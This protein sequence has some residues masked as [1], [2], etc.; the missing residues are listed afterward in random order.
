MRT[1]PTWWKQPS[2]L[3]FKRL[4]ALNQDRALFFLG[5]GISI[6]AGLPNWPD[7][8]RRLIEYLQA[9]GETV[10][11]DQL[12]RLAR[13]I[14]T[15]DKK[16]FPKVG[17]QLRNLFRPNTLW[18]TALN[19]IIDNPIGTNEPGITD[20]IVSLN[21]HCL[22]TTNYDALLEDAFQRRY[23]RDLIVSRPEKENERSL[24]H[25]RGQFIYKIHGDIRDEGSPIVLSDDDYER[26]YKS[27][28][29]QTQAALRGVLRTAKPILFAGYSHDDPY[30]QRFYQ[31]AMRYSAGDCAFA[32]VPIEGEIERFWKKL[33]HLTEELGITFIGYSPEEN[34]REILEFFQYLSDPDSFDAQYNRLIH[35]K[36]PTIV[37]LYCGGTIG[38]SESEVDADLNNLK[39]PLSV[40]KIPTRFDPRLGRLSER[41]SDWYQESYNLGSG[42]E[43]DL[44]WEV[45]PEETQCFSENA[46]PELW[47]VVLK[48]LE[49][50]VFKYF[51][52]PRIL[53]DVTHLEFD[54]D[55]QALP[56]YQRLLNLYDE[57]REQY[58]RAFDGAELT[59][60]QFIADFQSRYVLGIILLF[61]TD[62]MGYMVSA[63]SFGLQHM[64]C[65]IVVTGSNQPPDQSHFGTM[66]WFNKSD[67]WKNILTAVY[68]LQTF[69]HTLTD[70]FICFG[71]TIH[72]GVNVRK[73][74]SEMGPLAANPSLDPIS[75][76][77][78]GDPEPFVFRNLHIHGQYM[79]RLIDGIFCNNYYS[80]ER[81][82]YS[83][84]V[85]LQGE[86]VL[87]LRH[88]RRDPLERR[89]P[90]PRVIRSDFCDS[91]AILLIV[92]SPS[93]PLIDVET[94]CAPE[95][96][97]PL[98]VAL[99]E[100]YASGT[101]PT[102]RASNFSKLLSDLYK[103][104]IPIF[105]VSQY[106]ISES[107]QQYEVIALEGGL[108][109][110]V[111]VHRGLTIESA[112]PMFSLVLNGISD[113]E[114]GKIQ[115]EDKNTN[116]SAGSCQTLLAA[117]TRLIQHRLNAFLSERPNI[118][119]LEIEPTNIKKQHKSAQLGKVKYNLMRS[120]ENRQNKILSREPLS[121]EKFDSLTRPFGSK[122]V[123]L[124][125]EDFSV[126]VNE[127]VRRDER[128]GAG[129]DGFAALSDLGFDYGLSIVKGISK[130]L[131]EKSGHGWDKRLFERNDTEQYDLLGSAQI[132]MKE[133]TR[134]LRSANIA[135]VSV[136]EISFPK[137]SQSLPFEESTKP[138]FSFRITSTRLEE[139][140]YTD[141]KFTAVSF[142]GD[143]ADF[144]KGLATG[145][146][147]EET[148]K[149]YRG[150][151]ASYNRLLR[152]K[153]QHKTTFLDWLL[154]G[155]FKGVTCGIAEF[156]RFDDLAV[157][158]GR[159]TEFGY[160]Y[161]IRKAA[162][163]FVL[164]G[165]ARVFK[166]K[167]FYY[168][169]SRPSLLE[170]DTGKG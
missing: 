85:G 29:N 137:P 45:L 31:K 165:D 35:A 143:D 92:A 139:P 73:I 82:P 155:L 106:G 96:R 84:L 169:S 8:L 88:I 61:G 67:A 98:K 36:R 159:S 158:A 99:I 150:L 69:G 34:H 118:L 50:I 125:N 105:L 111:N 20:A 107:Q 54:A 65:S 78:Y 140:E 12:V 138:R 110:P 53:G 152:N 135:D 24:E 32:L 123:F 72:H 18:R 30:V 129:P 148:E 161:V 89:Q 86:G 113:E 130:K 39:S 9:H 62:T 117:R 128:K 21:W 90:H 44:R 3:K 28:E 6:R 51:E 144:F 149:H 101:Y 151:E 80:T 136:D 162:H 68:F 131:S 156:L 43:I 114:W 64:P 108:T 52:A 57:E 27:D 153:W 163:C 119:T 116:A 55:H 58:S 70:G 76:S 94:M 167:L 126:I 23:V 16:E 109:V 25:E 33:S 22:V 15:V 79:F 97:S 1:L 77:L 168:Q 147:S 13:A 14:E 102:T 38:S 10:P 103:N 95:N 11:R 120:E 74:A 142:S 91:S 166:I 60:R 59:S 112:L 46:T 7:L 75:A 5:S 122:Y 100:G 93:A 37:M 160:K 63:L 87:D 170:G 146:S 133:V 164:A 41:L 71:D 104:A 48:K 121:L 134:L 157:E 66:M 132:I 17:S 40:T 47:N 83:S 4:Y 26:I 42:V 81:V 19:K 2:F 141:E 154:V 145:C 115:D 56:N 124:F 49:D 127:I